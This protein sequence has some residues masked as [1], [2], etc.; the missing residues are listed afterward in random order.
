[1]P[2]KPKFFLPDIP[3]H[4]IV[5]GNDRKVFFAENEDKATYLEIAKETSQIKKGTDP[6]FH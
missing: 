4:A 6:F 2:R 3:I 1:M 5:R